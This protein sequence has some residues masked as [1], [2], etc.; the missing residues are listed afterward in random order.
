MGNPKWYLLRVLFTSPAMFTKLS[1]IFVPSFFFYWYKK[2]FIYT[3]THTSNGKNFLLFLLLYLLFLYKSF[4]NLSICCV[5]WEFKQNI[6]TPFLF[7]HSYF[8][9]Y[10]QHCTYIT[11]RAFK[12]RTFR[13]T[14]DKLTGTMFIKLKLYKYFIDIRKSL[15]FKML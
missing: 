13:I 9:I 11:S 2:M 8:T 12:L 1:L 7:I 14:G 6:E 3:Y 10:V 15:K 4:F 5:I